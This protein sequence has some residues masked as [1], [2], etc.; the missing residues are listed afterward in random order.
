MD[1]DISQCC[2]DWRRRMYL[3]HP[4]GVPDSLGGIP[5]PWRAMG[6]CPGE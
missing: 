5:Y 6:K 3:T 4:T 2:L 1:V